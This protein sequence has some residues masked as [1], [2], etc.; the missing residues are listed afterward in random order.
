[1]PTP[2]VWFTSDLHLRHKHILKHCPERI[3]VMGLEGLEGEEAMQKH[4]EYILKLW[5]MT[6]A[7]KDIVY[8]LGDF[9]FAPREWAVKYLSKMNGEKHLII[10]NHDQSSHNLAGYFKTINHIKHQ[11]FKKSV[12]PFLEEDLQVSMCHYPFVTWASKH[13][14]CVAL[15]GHCH[16]R[17]DDFNAKSTDLRVDV[18]LDGQLAKYGL[19]SLEQVYQHFKEKSDGKVLERYAIDMR[20]TNGMII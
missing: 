19:V 11:T 4:D 17:L 13:H 1:M 3:A 5:N 10:G 2:K 18:G 9:T 20:D 15:H 7:K 14:G 8:I 12:Y 16:G 6:V